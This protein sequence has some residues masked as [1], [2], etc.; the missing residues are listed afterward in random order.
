VVALR[1]EARRLASN[2]HGL[3]I[4]IAAELYGKTKCSDPSSIKERQN[5]EILAMF[6]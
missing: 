2:P 3:Q 6:S 1:T 4:A 5:Q